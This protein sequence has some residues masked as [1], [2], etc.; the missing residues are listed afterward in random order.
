MEPENRSL[1]GLFMSFQS[2]IEIPGVSN[3]HFLRMAY[4]ARRRAQNLPELEPLEVLVY[5]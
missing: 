5:L 4:N 3:D 1:A 2:P